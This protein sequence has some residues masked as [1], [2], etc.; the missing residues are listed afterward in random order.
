MSASENKTRRKEPSWKNVAEGMKD[1]G[2]FPEEVSDR[3]IVI[4][5]GRQRVV[6]RKISGQKWKVEYYSGKIMD[7]MVGITSSRFAKIE[8]MEMAITK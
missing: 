3:R 5:R 6:A 7:D 2:W 1:L 4:E 8:F